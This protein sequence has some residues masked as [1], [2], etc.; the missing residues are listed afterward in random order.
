MSWWTTVL[1]LQSSRV[2][3]NTLSKASMHGCPANT[4]L[5]GEARLL[6]SGYLGYFGISVFS[7]CMVISSYHIS[8]RSL[9]A[10][11]SSSYF[12]FS[13]LSL[14]HY[15]SIYRFSASSFSCC[16]SWPAW[17]STRPAFPESPSRTKSS[18]GPTSRETRPSL[19]RP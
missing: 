17:N 19:T 18:S 5:E 16:F 3:L 8:M 9:H 6:W 13:I 7:I 4:E 10:K 1:S 2:S 15:L 14:M 11:S 12:F